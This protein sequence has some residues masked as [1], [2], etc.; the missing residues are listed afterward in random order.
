MPTVLKILNPTT[1]KRKPIQSSLLPEEEKQPLELDKQL[2]VHSFV[3]ERD[4]VRVAFAR[5]SFK[6]FNTWYAFGGHVQII[7]DDVVVFPKPKPRTVKLAIPYK[8]QLDNE[9]NPT[10]SCN[11]TSLAMC[12]E[13]LGAKRRVNSGQFEDELYRY[14][15]N[16]GLSRH[17]PHD[18]AIIVEDYGCRDDFRTNATIE[19]AQDWLADGKPIVTHGYFTSFGH[20]VVLAGFD[21]KGFLVHDPY[22]EW[23]PRGYR[24]D[25]SG[26]YV[27]Y[28]YNMIRNIC[29]PDGSFWVH[30]ISK[31]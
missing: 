24:T 13:F 2:E 21:E 29:I 26:K 16:R 19:Q 9:E 30:F 28:S 6:G 15:I 22:G 14:A 10:G 5:D 31:K 8:S 12:L 11:V 7:K 23:T 3:I 1:L 20:I 27:N 17:D 4:H 18:L 25:L